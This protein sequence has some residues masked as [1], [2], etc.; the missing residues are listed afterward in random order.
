MVSTG[1]DPI[2][3][4][5]IAVSAGGAGL[6]RYNMVV[7]L[8]PSREHVCHNFLSYQSFDIIKDYIF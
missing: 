1:K 8:K 7:G 6:Y 3:L 2:I 5:Y 4:L